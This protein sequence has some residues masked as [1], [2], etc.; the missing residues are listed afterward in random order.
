MRG[1]RALPVWPLTC[2]QSGIAIHA[3][4]AQSLVARLRGLLGT[5]QPPGPSE[6]LLL[7]PA[8]SI[9]TV[10]MRYPIT[11]LYLDAGFRVIRR[12]DA[13]APGRW[14]RAPRRGHACLEMAAD[15]P[16]ALSPG[17]VLKRQEV[18]D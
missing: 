2:S 15:A 8:S 5:Q 18:L 16:L 14:L 12:H 4:A 11:V 10:G 1:W 6:A 7:M 17:S 3:F 13:V 9:H